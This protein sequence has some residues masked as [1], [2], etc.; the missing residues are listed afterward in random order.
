MI[1][2]EQTGAAKRSRTEEPFR[3]VKQ[4]AINAFDEKLNAARYRPLNESD[5]D[6]LLMSLPVESETDPR[7][8]CLTVARIAELAVVTLGRYVDGCDFTA[9]GDLLF[10]PKWI[11]VHV[12]GCSTPIRKERHTPLSEQLA[13]LMNGSAHVQ[14]LNRNTL[15]RTRR[16]ALLPFLR[17][18]LEQSG[19]ISPAYIEDID[20][21]CRKA[22]DAIAFLVSGRIFDHTDLIR[23]M[24]VGTVSQ[25]KFMEKHLCRFGWKK[26]HE[27]GREIQRLDES[28][29]A[30]HNPFLTMNAA[31]FPGPRFFAQSLCHY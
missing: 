6:T 12:N 10:N 1:R 24:R 25:R 22:A 27:L 4:N 18:V 20:R 28:G 26:F 29:N 8:L 11:D 2:T 21:R 15:V 16:K 17:D 14:W 7:R 3:S 5:F 19:M 9:A 13:P 23:R 30:T 31:P